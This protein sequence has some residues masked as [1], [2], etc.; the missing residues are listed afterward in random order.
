MTDSV[1]DHAQGD[2]S[3]KSDDINTSY[4]QQIES[5]RKIVNDRPMS[6]LQ[7]TV[8]ILCFI[9][10]MLDGMDV[11]LMSYAA[12]L[13]AND[14]LIEA[15]ALGAVFSAALAGMTFGCL[16][17]APYADVIGRRKMIMAAIFVIATGMLWSALC[18]TVTQLVIA[19]IYT[20]LG[21]GAI[22]AS[23]ATMT[24]EFSS[25]KRRNFCVAFLQAG[26]P[27]G[28]VITGFSSAAIM[29][30]FGWRPMFYGAAAITGIMLPLI[31]LYLPESLEFLAK[32]QPKNALQDINKTLARMHLAPIASL[33]PKPVGADQKTSVKQL[34]ANGRGFSTCMLWGGVFFGFFTLYFVISWIPKIAVDAG[35]PLEKGIYAGTAYNLGSIVGSIFLGWISSKFGLQRMIF[36]FF[37]VAAG[38]LIIFGSVQMSVFFILLCAFIIGISLNGGFNGFW[39]T[40]AR[41]YPTEIRATGIGWAVG[42]GRAGAVLGPLIGGFLLS[43]GAGLETTFYVFA[44]P[45]LIAGILTLFIRSKDFV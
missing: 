2:A 45:T 22:L 12:P 18:H 16:A 43:S 1:I 35:L 26:F 20:G 11:V 44:V 39:P 8:V 31:Y 27:L 17:I 37:T 25:D 36:A 5:L 24:A 15:S 40:A 4:Q 14:W 28:A 41:L 21:V 13:L 33:P 29:P 3:Q 30:E 23:M 19:R 10:N 7:V 32:K 38:M 34:F 9:L 6:A 42:A